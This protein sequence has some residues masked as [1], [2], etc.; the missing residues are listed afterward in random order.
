MLVSLF[1]WIAKRVTIVLPIF[2]YHKLAQSLLTMGFGLVV[3]PPA[4]EVVASLTGWEF[5]LDA[6]SVAGL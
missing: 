1:V 5:I 2:F 3:T 6:L 4:K